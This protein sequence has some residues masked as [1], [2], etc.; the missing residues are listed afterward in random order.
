MYRYF[1]IQFPFNFHQ[2][3]SMFSTLIL[4]YLIKLIVHFPFKIYFHYF[5]FF[6][7]IW[8]IFLF[9]FICFFLFLFR[10]NYLPPNTLTHT[11][12]FDSLCLSLMDGPLFHGGYLRKTTSVPSSHDT[13]GSTSS[14]TSSNNDNELAQ[15][16][17]V[18]R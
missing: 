16:V 8:M 2:S 15:K 7:L 11:H 3:C 9:C 4:V 6:N 17:R 12:T 10:L 18:S 5:N 13:R 1:S 14:G